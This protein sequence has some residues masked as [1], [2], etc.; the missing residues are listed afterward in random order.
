MGDCMTFILKGCPFCGSPFVQVSTF[1]NGENT[2][3]S[4]TCEHC[5]AEGPLEKIEYEA[6]SKWNKRSIT[7]E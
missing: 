7:A 2:T 3:Y 5:K 6:M 4:V 1:P